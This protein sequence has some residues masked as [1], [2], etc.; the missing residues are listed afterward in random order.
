[1]NSEENMSKLQQIYDEFDNSYQ[2]A[3]LDVKCAIRQFGIKTIMSEIENLPEYQEY[4][5]YS[6]ENDIIE[7]E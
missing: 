5:T 4:L 7:S 6:F 3:I 2:F 1:M